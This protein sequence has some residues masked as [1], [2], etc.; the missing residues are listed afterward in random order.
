[1]S[2]RPAKR[3]RRGHSDPTAGLQT[4]A[5]I[6]AEAQALAQQY[7][8]QGD[9]AAAVERARL[10]H[11][12]VRGAGGPV[13]GSP[14]GPVE[15][16][17]IVDGIGALALDTSDAPVRLAKIR[18][19][20]LSDPTFEPELWGA[21]RVQARRGSRHAQAWIMRLVYGWQLYDNLAEKLG[22]A[23]IDEAR[24]AL[25]MVSETR[26]LS[27]DDLIENGIQF[28]RWVRKAFPEKWSGV[29][30][31]LGKEDD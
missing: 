27:E 26:T 9:E 8:G 24:A 11:P 22:G 3:A 25:N 16:K 6:E 13:E 30:L 17:D 14:V 18:T 21:M 29:Y 15:G 12:T 5:E 28:F 7:I 1:M 2:K 4:R 31:R 23:T 19:W 20:L 10:L